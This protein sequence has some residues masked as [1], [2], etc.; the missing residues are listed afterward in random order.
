MSRQGEVGKAQAQ[1][2]LKLERD[3]KDNTE[4]SY[5]YADN[6]RKTKEIVRLLLN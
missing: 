5:R 4:G 3:V 6:K 2:E 1:L